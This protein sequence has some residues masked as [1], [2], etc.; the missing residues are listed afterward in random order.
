MACTANAI[1]A[2]LS[3]ATAEAVP[4]Q[5]AD[6]VRDYLVAQGVTST[7]VTA[8]GFGKSRPV[9]SNDSDAG[10]QQ[11]RRV[12]LVVSGEPIGIEGTLDPSA[13]NRR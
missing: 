11:N 1:R 8:R 7:S 3:T 9:A 2:S 5:R 12:E 10:R 13:M 6:T 4:E